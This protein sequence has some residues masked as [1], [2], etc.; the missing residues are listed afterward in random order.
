MIFGNTSNYMLKYEKAKS[1]LVE[2]NIAEEN[3]PNFPL[4]PDD[5]TYSTLYALSRYCEMLI[6]KP[7]SPKLS[8]L[9]DSLI[10]TSQYYDATVKT[11]KRQSYNNIFS[12]LGAT[13]YFLSENFGNSKVLILQI[14]KWEFEDNICSLL[15]ISL[16]FLLIGEWTDIR[17]SKEKYI[18]YINNLKQHFLFGANYAAI[19][20]VLDE[21]RMDV[22]SNSDLLDVNY[23][24]FLYAV[25][26]CA[27]DHSSWIL[28]PEKSKLEPSRWKDYLNK[29]DSIKLLWPAQKV[30][31]QA[32]AL[33]GS[34]LVVPLP[35]GVGKTKSIEIIL[36]AKFMNIGTNSCVVIAPLRA[37]CNEI[38]NDLTAAFENEA[39]INQFTDTMQ[40]DFN[41][42]LIINTK[43]VFICTP[44][45]FSY[46]LRHQPEF[47]SS[48]ELFVFDEAHLFDDITRGAQYELLVS[49]IVRKKNES[50]QM[51]LFSA[52]L[53][54]ANQISNWLFNDETATIDNNLVKSTEKSIG[55]VSSDQTIHYF[56]KD[57]MSEE[58]F[59]IPRSI[60]FKNLQLHI[61][62]RKIKVFPQKNV[63]DISIYYAIKLC[64]N[65]G[66]AI[67]A[68][69]T[70]SIGPIMRRI[71]DIQ[72]RGYD[73]SNLL[74]N[75]NADEVAKLSELFSANY[76]KDSELTQAVSLGAIPHYAYLPN[77]IKLATEHALRKKHF[78]F[79]VCTT[80]LAEGVNIPI[81]YL[82]L[83]T[84][85]HGNASVQIRKLQNLIGRTARSGVHTEGSAIVTDPQYYDKRMDSRHGGKYRWSDCKKMFDHE[86]AEACKSTILSLISSL[87]VDYSITFK[88]KAVAS[89]LLSNYDTPLCFQNM[90]EHI[91]NAYK[92]K[93]PT[94][95]YTKYSSVIDEKVQQI[96]SIVE[97]IENYLC[98]IY[99]SLENTS[100][101]LDLVSQLAKSTFA[102]YLADDE[103]KKQLTSIFHL[104][105]QKITN[106]ISPDKAS[107]FAKSMFGIKTSKQ[108]LAW[109]DENI[110]TINEYSINQLLEEMINLLLKLFPNIINVKSKTLIGIAN[111]WI[112]GKPYIEIYNTLIGLDIDIRLNQVEK[113]CS[114]VLSY[115]LSF[116]IGNILDALADQA[117]VLKEKLSILQKQVKY[118]VPNKFQILI[119]EN[120]FYDRIVAGSLDQS[121]GQTPITEKW[122]KK[123]IISL[124]KEILTILQ[125]YP[126]YFKYKFILYTKAK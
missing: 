42:E 77:G 38:A 120:I 116:L 62:E 40:E 33:T 32:G 18:L 74:I 7:D 79:V 37:L 44:E 122:F 123:Y 82:F 24:D 103:G 83:T 53:S 75:S 27:I 47:I 93:V 25:I 102:Y 19:I 88:G 106:E 1:K 84:F 61:K 97:S 115:H 49:E 5:L 117:E 3:Y 121:F 85:S 39:V 2:F 72:D 22:Y 125:D 111:L 36:R 118:G 45:K 28:L 98:Y 101:F 17:I 64:K 86:N 96:E 21:I 58:S 11:Q 73:I 110:D 90:R 50:A 60:D 76:G 10:V 80:T 69:Q 95:Q 26:I 29:T 108:I 81:K 35:T 56:E 6:E 41:I 31:I 112:S 124:R 43:Y 8:N 30:I 46:I 68:G 126:D 48:I 66:V 67:Y 34:N 15:Y 4:N 104:I 65:G 113:L 55:F 107:Y 13:S 9:F 119:C 89:Y 114:N 52:V 57:N 92:D 99:Y 54:N 23:F 70:R 51:I 71:V 14:E 109:L 20:N 87:K 12:L 59:F 78:H 105:A 100:S 94:E 63:R 91:K 16:Y